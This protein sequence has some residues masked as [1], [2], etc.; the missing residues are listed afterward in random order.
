[1]EAFS[2]LVFLLTIFLVFKQ[3]SIKIPRT[4]KY[5]HIDYGIA[6]LLGAFLLFVISSF[7]SSIVINGLLGTGSMKPYAILIIILS[8]SYICASLDYTGFFEYL[9]IKMMKVAGG[10]CF[11]LFALIFLLSSILTLFTD[12]DVV[13][14]TLT[15]LIIYLAK[16][17]KIHPLP[18]LLAEFFAVNIVGVGIYIGNPTNIIGADAYGLSFIEYA[19]WMMLPAIAGG[20]TCFFILWAI[21]KSEI[22]KKFAIV[23][24]QPISAIK[25]KE[26]AVFGTAVLFLT[27]F[28]MSL[29]YE[30]TQAPL[31]MISLFFA[32][33]MLIHDI[34]VYGPYFT[35]VGARVPWKLG[36]FLFGF[37]IITEYL[38]FT[39]VP[40]ILGSFLSGIQDPFATVFVVMLVSSIAAG[41]MNNHPMSIFFVKAIYGTQSS[42][43]APT[44]GLI[45]GSSFG[46]NLML[47]GSLA[48]LMWAR[49]LAERGK[50]ISFSEFSKYGVL[51][52]LPV[53][54]VASLVI[55]AELTFF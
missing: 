28:F 50:P 36:P 55:A 45:A 3:P 43:L 31:W 19:K 22:L 5:I 16:S 35:D 49:I 48:G 38:S 20:L 30:I 1:M 10:S 8:L 15:F 41:F 24:P 44:L 40:G 2:I 13:I 14:L 11:K 47:T 23:L 4:S 39:G 37:F 17:A 32:L 42:K 26:S 21:F 46:G 9:A 33:A 34:M 51:V 6:P 53:I 29:P 52:M 27:I 7:N 12:N 54:A 18:F 25:S